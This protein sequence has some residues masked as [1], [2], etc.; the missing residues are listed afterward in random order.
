MGIHGG[1]GGRRAGAGGCHGVFLARR[2]WR[3][4]GAAE[5]EARRVSTGCVTLRTVFATDEEFSAEHG[6]GG[7]A[8]VCGRRAG[9]VGEASDPG[10]GR[11]YGARASFV[12]A[13]AAGG[14]QAADL[15]SAL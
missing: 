7:D 12:G 15:R 4:G 11:D 3:A 14:L 6:S 8:D 13:I 1:G 10:T 9:P 2:A 5:N